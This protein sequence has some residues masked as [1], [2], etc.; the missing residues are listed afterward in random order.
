MRCKIKEYISIG[1]AAEIL[2]ISIPGVFAANKRGLITLYQI[3]NGINI[4]K[5]KDIMQYKKNRKK[6]NL[7][8]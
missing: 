6:Q 3:E 8:K 1:K 7:K 4:V 2:G 5:L